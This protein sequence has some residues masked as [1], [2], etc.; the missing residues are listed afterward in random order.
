MVSVVLAIVFAIAAAICAIG[1]LC[2]WISCAAML[3]Y[4]IGKGYTLP[5]DE[6]QRACIREVAIRTFR[7]KP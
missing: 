3:M 6:E 7:L 4:M 5:T 1:W 2:Y